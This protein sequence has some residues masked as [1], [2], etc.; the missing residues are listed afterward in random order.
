[1]KK[2]IIA[3]AACVFA[4]CFA[5]VGCGG[6]G[7]DAK[8]AWVGSWD[9]IEMEENG[10]V[11]SADDLQMLKDLGLEVYF[12]VNE[13]GTCKLMLLGEGMEGT[14]EAKSAT[15]ATFTLEQ[16]TI[17]ATIADSKMV[18]E[19]DGS[20]SKL[21]FQKGQPKQTPSASSS[22]A[23]TA[24]SSSSSSAES[25]SAQSASAESTSASAESASA[26]STSASAESASA[27]SASASAESASAESAS[28]SSA[29]AESA[30]ASSAS[31][32]SASAQ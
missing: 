23:S 14:W 3:L 20:N 19:Q 16:Q 12:E 4:L 31:A 25:T 29:S 18:M 6:S 2:G 15:E 17:K 27:E 30:S 28:A 8:A 22:A 1:M 11:T 9:L 13:D 7:S 32:S 10:E 21:T 26:E 5:L 24:S